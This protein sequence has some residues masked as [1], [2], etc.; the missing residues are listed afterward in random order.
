[1]QVRDRPN[2]A[3]GAVED[4][5]ADLVLAGTSQFLLRVVQHR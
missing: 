4:G 5:F 2:A 1:M 3:L